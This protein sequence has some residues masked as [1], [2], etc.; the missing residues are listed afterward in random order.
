MFTAAGFGLLRRATVRNGLA[1]LLALEAGGIALGVASWRAA[2]EAN[3]TPTPVDRT[4]SIWWTANPARPVLLPP[5]LKAR[6]AK[7]RPDEMVIGVEVGTR[8]RAYRL[9]AFDDA[10]G[11]LVNDVIAG[12]PVSVAYSGLTHCA[13]V[14]TDPHGS[15][16]LE[17]EVAGLFNFEMV[18]RLGG[19]LYYQRSG[20]PLEPEKSPP[21]IPYGLLTPSVTTW[22]EWSQH[23]PETDVYVGGR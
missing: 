3:R 15:A 1:T 13:R 8:S 18:M 22:K 4:R 11:H 2:R 20:L 7:I 17:I 9:V 10:S 6:E 21:P 19:S 14:Y 23:H 16:P 12:V 5:T